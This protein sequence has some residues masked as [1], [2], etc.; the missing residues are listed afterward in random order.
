ME[1]PVIRISVRNLVEFILRSGDLDTRAGNVPDREA[2]LA[3][4]RAH[5]RIQKNRKGTYQS[6]V[7]LSHDCEF[8]DFILRIEGRADGV[9]REGTAEGEDASGKASGDETGS[10]SGG[11]VTVEEIKG[12]YRDLDRM[13]EPA[14]VHLAQAKCYAS[15]LAR[16]DDLPSV[17]IQMTY[18]HLDTE[19]TKLFRSE[20]ARGELD[21]WFD[22]LA[23]E[24][25]KWAKFL[26]DH[27][28]V[29]DESMKELAFP[30]P[31]RKGQRELVAAVWHTISEGKELFIEAPT[32]VGKTMSVVFPAVRALGGGKGDRIFYLTSKTVTRTVG[33]EA[34]SILRARGLK[35]KLSALTAKEKLCPLNEPSCN[36]DDCPYAKGHFD[37]IND[38]VFDLLNE[39]DLF[40]RD[41]IMQKA[42]ER[43]VCPFELS[44]DVS[45]W[46]DAVI[47]DYNYAFDPNVRL[48]RFFGE[49]VKS[50]AILLVDEAHNLVDRGRE[51]YSA[52]LTKE[53]VLAA[54][55]I[56][57]D[58]DAALVKSLEKLNRQM[59]EM[60]RGCGEEKPGVSSGTGIGSGGAKGD[61]QYSVLGSAGVIVLPLLRIQEQ[62]QEFLQNRAGAEEKKALQDFFFEV[63]D[64]LY[65]SEL[66][67]ENYVIYSE[68]DEEGKFTVRQFCVNP[69]A[70]LQKCID[71][72]GCA[73]LFSATLLPISYYKKL[74][75][76]HEDDYAVYA[77]SP[78]AAEQKLLLIGRDVS[79][80]YRTRGSGTYRRIAQYI[81]DTV[82]MKKGNYLA[83]FPSYKMMQDVFEIYRSEFDREGV[84]WV[85]QMPSMREEDREIFLE[86]FYEDPK[87]TLVGF[88]VMG[89]IFAEGIDLTGTRLIGA[90]V[91]GTGL[92][93]LSNEKEI[94]RN[95]YSENG[96]DGFGYAY[97]IPGMN[98][99]LQAAGRVIRTQTDRGIILLL[100]DRFLTR[101][102]AALFP[103]EWTGGKIVQ[104]QDVR[105]V[106]KTFWDVV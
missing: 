39:A 42:E 45:S 9:Y 63:R 87:D 71:R 85:V 89:G 53:H 8:E 99:V 104:V 24:Y 65:V 30:F 98:K 31:Y 18:V 46:V 100:D 1:K 6:E 78:F 37:R 62:L 55:K 49:G 43:K 12:I 90:I 5:R 106:L 82:G 40:D 41:A 93:Q 23:E 80:R 86:N 66:V 64:F 7:V 27:R 74:L 25:H 77:E 84:N 2:M 14:P 28:K 67:D 68:L 60:K 83:F 57:N 73:V 16:R 94:L 3:G 29:R 56:L 72:A 101:E 69:S 15:I 32:G 33:L 91:I 105:E 21:D 13:E 96:E 75:S 81:R 50:N 22:R 52:S 26:V 35:L 61:T 19:K 34:F 102:Y 54:K 17:G 36:P 95:Y 88:C 79:T 11:A 20:Y 4:G 76:T 92:P 59:L 51:M 48:K 10:A 38:A 58:R 103:R 97:R 70:N 44:L 47:C